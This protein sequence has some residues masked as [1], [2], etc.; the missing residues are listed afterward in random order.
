MKKKMVSIMTILGIVMG[1]VAMGGQAVPVKAAGVE[2][3]EAIL[4]RIRM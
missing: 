4:G 3:T 2:I 1:S